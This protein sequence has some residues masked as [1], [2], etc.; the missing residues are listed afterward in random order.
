MFRKVPNSI[1]DIFCGLGGEGPYSKSIAQGSLRDRGHLIGQI[2]YLNEKIVYNGL[3]RFDKR[4][5]KQMECVEEQ[6]T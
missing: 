1:D 3:D 5:R 4:T 2:Q 6:I